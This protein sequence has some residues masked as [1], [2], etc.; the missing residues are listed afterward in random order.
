MSRR[1]TSWFPG[2]A[3]PGASWKGN[4]GAEGTAVAAAAAAPDLSA[5]RDWPPPG[6]LGEQDMY[7]SEKPWTADLGL[8]LDWNNTHRGLQ[9]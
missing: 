2:S 1:G 3:L 7:S 5:S 6:P 9:S 8:I 4:N